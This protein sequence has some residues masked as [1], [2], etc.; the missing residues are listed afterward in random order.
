MKLPDLD[1]IAVAG[2]PKRLAGIMQAAKKAQ[3]GAEV[4][5]IHLKFGNLGK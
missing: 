3:K 4:K 5:K 1:K 2:T